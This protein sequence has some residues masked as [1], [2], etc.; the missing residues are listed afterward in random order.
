MEKGLLPPLLSGGYQQKR[1]DK[2]SPGTHQHICKI[3]CWILYARYCT[4][5]VWYVPNKLW[6]YWDYYTRARI[7]HP[8]RIEWFH[9]RLYVVDRPDLWDWWDKPKNVHK[10]YRDGIFLLFVVTKETKSSA[11]KITNLWPQTSAV[12]QPSRGFVQGAP[13]LFSSLPKFPFCGQP[14]FSF[15]TVSNNDTAECPHLPAFLFSMI[16]AVAVDL[17]SGMH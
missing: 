11:K 5:T 7:S 2:F 10:H 14:F 8:S 12:K 16:N 6:G 17:K 3:S 9:S 15:T 1:G 4:R 13:Q